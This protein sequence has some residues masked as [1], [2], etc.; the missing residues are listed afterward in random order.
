[1]GGVLIVPGIRVTTRRKSRD[2]R[3]GGDRKDTRS[4]ASSDPRSLSASGQGTPENGMEHPLSPIREAF[5][6]ESGML[7]SL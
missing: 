4:L 5:L 2:R 7:L 3:L 1:M 6:V